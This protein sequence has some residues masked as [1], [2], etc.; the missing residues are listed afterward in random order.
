MDT[1]IIL[2]N[3]NERNTNFIPNNDVNFWVF[4]E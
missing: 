2:G 3:F 1:Y 4:Y